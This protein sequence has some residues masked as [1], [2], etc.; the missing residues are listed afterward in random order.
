MLF[1][2][3]LVTAIVLLSV[4]S[5]AYE[6]VGDSVIFENARAKLVVT[7]HTINSSNKID[8]DFPFQVFELTNKTLTDAD[9]YPAYVFDFPLRSGTVE[10]WNGSS[11]VSITNQ[12]SLYKGKIWGSEDDRF[13]YHTTSDYSILAGETKKWRISYKPSLFDTTEKWDLAF[14]VGSSWDCI[15]DSSCNFE[16][17]LDPWFNQ[18]FPFRRPINITGTHSV[19]DTNYT[20]TLNLDTTSSDFVNTDLN[21]LRVIFVDANSELVEL[22]R[23]ID[24]PKATDSI[25][26][27]KSRIGILGNVDLNGTDENGYWIYYGDVSAGA[28]PKDWVDVYWFG[29]DFNRVSLTASPYGDWNAQRVGAGDSVGI[30]NGALDLN[31]TV[32]LLW[33]QAIFK[34]KTWLL[35]TSISWDIV[36]GDD[37]PEQTRIGAASCNTPT[38][39]EGCS[40]FNRS[41]LGNAAGANWFCGSSAGGECDS[42]NMNIVADT[43]YDFNWMSGANDMNAWFEGSDTPFEQSSRSTALTVSDASYIGFET[44][45]G[46]TVSIDWLKIFETLAVEP[47]ISVGAQ[48]DVSSVFADFNSSPA[49]PYVLDQDGGVDS[50][51]IDFNDTSTY[52]FGDSYASTVWDANGTEFSTDQNSSRIFSTIGD[53][54]ITQIVTSTDGNVSQKERTITIQQAGQTIDINF[55]FKA[56]T[57]LADV[58]F[59]VT[60][61][62]NADAINFAVWGFPNDKNLSGLVVNQQYRV[63]DVKEVCVVVNTTGDVN[64]VACENFFIT[65]VITKIPKDITNLSN[66]TPFSASIDSIP[67]Q[68]FS[69]VSVDQ[70]F[71]FFNQGLDSNTHNLIVDANVSFFLSTYFIGLNGV[72]LNQTIQPYMVPATDGINVIITA[73]DSLTN[74]TVAGVVARF[75]RIVSTDGSVEV[76]SGVT[77]DLGRISL[78]FIAGIDHNFTI[79]FPFG[80]ILRVGTYI[81]QT[82]DA[83]DGIGISVAS[84]SV[85]DVNA[86]GVTDTNFLQSQVTPQSPVDLNVI[87]TST[88]LISAVTATVDHNGVELDTDSNSNC[89]VTCQFNF[90]VEVAGL[91]ESFPLIIIVDYNY[92]DGGTL[93]VT[94]A[95]TISTTPFRLFES[96][97]TAKTRDL[98]DIGGTMF[99]SAIIIAIILGLVHFS[100]PSI[101]NSFT[102]VF[103]ATILLFLSFVG[104]VDGVTWVIATIGAGAV[105]FMRRVD[106]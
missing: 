95:V 79:Q 76:I 57:A 23:D 3:L 8:S 22:D 103:A 5:N 50:I 65:K 100:F 80:T 45:A 1:R 48:E 41:L 56:E 2:F 37:P 40:S 59:G 86:I 70:N 96:F 33:N 10:R 71:W 104:W 72:D 93:Q 34:E 89:P 92:V 7:P 39:I 84:T 81:P 54:N 94:K 26:K 62:G 85:F 17:V 51:T 46:F 74:D 78:P 36:S 101:D 88:R 87:I 73:K 52:L 68:S 44:L 99:L 31:G 27:W 64:K 9:V 58:N 55:V 25:I 77:D 82:I 38:F 90:S 53:F 60:V 32:S 67:P 69:S 105:Y 28:P 66:I 12:F 35:E 20:F 15:L 14:Y 98:G 30:V 43:F 102:F 13:I 19:I 91:N 61:D 16:W 24:N 47:T 83:T 18:A 75:D 6:I 21:D 106:K 49:A 97:T 11:W 63:G 29:D 42:K 4:S